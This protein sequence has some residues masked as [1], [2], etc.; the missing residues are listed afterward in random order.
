MTEQRSV[1]RVDLSSNQRTE[2][3]QVITGGAV[4]RVTRANFRLAVGTRIPSTVR[5]YDV[6]QTIVNIVPEYRG[7]RYIVVGYELIIIDPYT[8]EIVAIVP[9]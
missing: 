8:L 9:V 5:I 4:N 2:L 1:A 7:F 3:H 6:P